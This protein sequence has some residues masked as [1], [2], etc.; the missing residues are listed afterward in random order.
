MN[1]LSLDAIRLEQSGQELYVFKISGKK[2]LEL[3]YVDRRAESKSGIQR[4]LKTSRTKK[5]GKFIDSDDGMF[6]NSIIVNI[7]GKADFRPDSKNAEQG[8]LEI[9]DKEHS[10]WIVDGQHRVN[11]FSHSEKDFDVIVT[12]LVNADT[13]KCAAIF[14][15]IN[16]E[17]KK[18]NPSLAYDL[19]GLLEEGF[20]NPRD[21]DLHKVAKQ[22][23]S[24]QNGPFYNKIIMVDQGEGNVSQAALITKLKWFLK[25][26][27]GSRFEVDDRVEID[28][29]IKFD[30]LK[31][32]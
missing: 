9:E 29:L 5:I 30:C 28:A 26:K 24:S 19:L 22:L 10:M 25:D 11:G 2:L 7:E 32:S 14:Y 4:M 27:I 16:K 8:T 12:G 1:K 23:N 13:S 3:S 21:F 31:S 20:E 6:P 15:K 17:A 18:V